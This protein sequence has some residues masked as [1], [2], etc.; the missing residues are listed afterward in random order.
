MQGKTITDELLKDV[1]IAAAGVAI[2]DLGSDELNHIAGDLVQRANNSIKIIAV[3][4]QLEFLS[5]ME[6]GGKM[7][8]NRHHL[9]AMRIASLAVRPSVATYLDKMLHI[10]DGIHRIEEVFIEE[11][12]T[13]I[14]KTLKEV[15]DATQLK[16]LVIGIEDLDTFDIIPR[17]KQVIEKGM[18]LFIQGEVSQIE[19]FRKL[20]E[21][22]LSFSDF[23]SQS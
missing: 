9:C 4:D 23:P 21:G 22:E 1:N 14:G 7:A 5:I 15:F 19:T 8:V 18:P 17:G 3:N 20:A 13:I 2:F 6:G 11:K 12:S 16:L 10:Q